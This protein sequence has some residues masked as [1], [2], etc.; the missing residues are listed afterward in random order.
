MIRRVAFLLLMFAVHVQADERILSYHSDIHIRADGWIEV[1]ETIRVRAEGNQIRRGIYRDYPTDYEDQFG[2]RYQALYEIR[3]V[4]RDGAPEPYRTERLGNGVRTYF[5]SSNVFLTPG[6]YT[7]VFR[8]EAGRM[9][10][11]FDDADELWWNVTGNGWAF[12]IDAASATVTFD[13]EVSPGDL[14]LDAWQGTYGSRASADAML[15]ASRNPSYAATRTLFDG[16]GLTLSV[17]WPKGFVTE[18]TETQKLVWLLT[19]NINLLVALAGLAAMLGYY[20]PVWRSYGKDPAPGVI[21]TRYEPPEGFSPASLRYIA[22]MGY[23]NETMTA[24]VINLAVKG[25]LKINAGDEYHSLRRTD[26]GDNPPALAAGEKALLDALFVEYSHL[27]LYDMNHE[28]IGGAKKAHEKSLKADY[29][30][31]YFVTN[32]L[33]N[34]PPLMIFVITA[35]VAL[36]IGPSPMVIATIIGS[37]FA[38]ATFAVLL[39]RPTSL[40]RALLDESLG[41]EEYL[42]IAEKDELNLRNPPEKT[43]E[44][45]EQY[46]PFALT[47]GVEQDWADRFAKI[48]SSLDGQRDTS[49]QPTWYNGNWNNIDL[50]VTTL[51]MSSGLDTAI[52]SSASPP[53]SSSSGGGGGFSGG[54]GGGGGG[55]GW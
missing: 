49:Y 13:F 15:D 40:G 10:G 33:L 30:K 44:L 20:I 19:D 6:E 28:I 8:Y 26:P 23:D 31:R 39:K 18:P 25:Y 36:A 38:M 47:L 42:K 14:Q 34:L 22:N 29:H 11:F 7:Y 55:G 21:M 4:S 45:F 16:E 43:P 53:G 2:N 35:I 3:T 12:P 51:A 5:G 41:F 54:G 9:L 37:L 48:F 32:G 17:R 46:L 52:S 50:S 1:A 24:G 27:T